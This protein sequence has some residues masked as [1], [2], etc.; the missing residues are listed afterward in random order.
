[1]TTDSIQADLKTV[2]RRLKL[3]R[4]LDTLPE[5]LQLARQQ[6]LPPQDFLL[7]V[8]SDEATRRDSLAVALRV[9]RARLDP[10]QHLE[11]WDA[12]AKVTYDRALLNELTS[13]R[14]LETHAH[15]AIVGPVGVGKTFL[16]QALG[17]IACRRGYS[18]LA[19]RTD[20]MLKTLKRKNAR[21]GM[22]SIC[23]GGGL[24]G[25]MLLEAA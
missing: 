15:V 20:H 19:L 10:A 16:A 6:Q 7:L 9:Q 23:I 21:R 5:R 11:A 22:A 17:H 18:V 24:G 3:G 4:M 8:L 25:A 1:M 14:F 2:L 13:L 12:T